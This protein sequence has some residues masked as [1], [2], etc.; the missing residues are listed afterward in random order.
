ML[1]YIARRLGWTAVLLFVISLAAYVTFFVLPVNRGAAVRR[2]G[3]EAQ[4]LRRAVPLTG[5]VLQEY[6]QFVW[7]IAARGDLGR[8]FRTREDVT[9][10]L[11]KAAPATGSLLLGGLL[12]TLLIALPISVLSALR[13][14]SLIDKGGMVIAL[15]G[16]SIHPVSIGLGLSFLLGHKLTLLPLHGYCDVFGPDTACGGPRQWALHLLLPWLTFALVFAAM[17]ARMLRATL[18]EEL[19]GEHIVTARAK[20]APELRIVLVHALR[21]ASL[22][23][24]TMIGMD[25][26]RWVMTLVFVEQ[27]FNLPG[28]GRT[29]LRAL[30]SADLPVILGVTLVIAVGVTLLNLVA[31][32]LYAV[33]DPRLR[34]AGRPP[35][36]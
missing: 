23:V 17:Y 2:T 6:G 8:S 15:I 24:V 32:V 36:G 30:D 13:P 16:I 19:S 22:P 21:S 31:D 20:G 10:V 12:L 1:I 25:L 29:L 9:T 34:L 28:L 26:A 18:I 5:N 33:L 11:R 3:T 27:V 35:G 7:G 4:D 14:R